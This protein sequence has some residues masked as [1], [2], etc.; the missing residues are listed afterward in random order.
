MRW[1]SRDDFDICDYILLA[2]I[3][4]HIAYIVKKPRSCIWRDLF[5]IGKVSVFPNT[6][7]LFSLVHQQNETIFKQNDHF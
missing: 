1:M 2:L 7:Y 4:I 3:C 5:T 6:L